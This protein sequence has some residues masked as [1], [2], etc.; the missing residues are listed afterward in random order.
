MPYQLYEEKMSLKLF[1]I[2]TPV[3]SFNGNKLN[4]TQRKNLLQ[5][6]YKGQLLISHF[7]QGELLSKFHQ[8]HC[9][10][11]FH[12]PSIA[13]DPWLLTA[14]GALN[15]SQKYRRKRVW[16][17][18]GF[19]FVGLRVQTTGLLVFYLIHTDIRTAFACLLYLHE[20]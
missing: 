15:E 4:K 14:D 20:V 9:Y 8:K 13:K 3:A 17:M 5:Y 19:N 11:T 12:W 1:E 7:H 6:W 16:S 10:G 2:V 18:R